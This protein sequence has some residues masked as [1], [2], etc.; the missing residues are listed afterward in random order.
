MATSYLNEPYQLPC[1]LQLKN[2]IAK[3]AMTERLANAKNGA[4]SKHAALYGH[5]AAQGAGLLITGNIMVDR[6][7]KE[8]AGN[9]VLEDES[10]LQALKGLT[11]AATQDGTQIWAQISHA[12]RQSSIFSTFKPIAPSAVHLKRLGLFAKPRA[13][14]IGEI[15]EVEERFIKTA[16]LCQQAGFTGIQIHAAH[17]YLL[18]QFLSPRTNLRTDEY[19]GALTNRARLLYNIIRRLRT[20]LG[21]NYPISVKLN[22]ADFQRGGFEEEDALE[23]IKELESLGIDL[24]EISGGTYENVNFLTDRYQKESTRQREAYFMDFAEMVRKESAIPLMITGG[25]RSRAFCEEVLQKQELDIIGFARPFL[26][27]R[28]FPQSFLKEDGAQVSDARFDFKLKN[29]RD[30]AEAAYFDYQIHRL[31]K[32]KALKPQVNPYWGV[33]RFTWNEMRKGWFKL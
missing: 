20:D 24:L 29:L 2:R 4:N 12:G 21:T 14:T 30:M 5:W 15:Q 16:K 10:D 25:F 28:H 19:G 33:L 27:D 23:V 31:A 22:S 1:G 13:M 11:S 18:N 26:M 17:G 8:S 32:G 6:R 3:A 7:Y 9:I